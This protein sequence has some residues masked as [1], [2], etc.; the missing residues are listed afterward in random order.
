M[1]DPRVSMRGWTRPTAL[2]FALLCLVGLRAHDGPAMGASAQDVRAGRWET[3]ANGDDILVLAGEGDVLWA[4][5]RAGGL[6]RW[7]AADGRYV[8]YLRPQ[9][10]LGGNTVTD[11]A[12]DA[13][14]RKWLATD[15]GLTMLD[16]K[17]TAD[18][19]DDVWR[20]YTAEATYG[21]LPSDDV[22]TVAVDG[23]L[24]WVGTAQVWNP[25]TGAYEGG[26]LAR[27]DTK[28][29]SATADDTWMPPATFADTITPAPD[30]T[31]DLGLVSDNVT[32]LV[33]TADR[34][35]WVATAPHWLYEKPPV[36]ELEARWGR[37]HGGIS[38][39]DTKG[40][41]DPS[42]DKWTANDCEDFQATITCSVQAMAL[43]ADGMVWAAIGGRGVMYFPAATPVIVDERSRRFDLESGDVDDFVEGIA[44]GPADDP[45]FADTVWLARRK[46][47]LSVLDHNGTL[48]NR[49]DDLW[50]LDR[51]QP[52]G[53]ADGL[54]ADRV[55]AVAVSG[56]R[57]WAGTGAADG[58][59]GGLSP[60][61]LRDLAVE[62][63]LRTTNAPP[64]NFLTALDF[65][66][67]GTKWAGHVWL[68]TGSRAQR[69][70]GAGVVDLDTKGTYDRRDDTWTAYTSAG[71]DDDGAAPWSGLAGDNVQAVAVAGDRVWFGSAESTWSQEARRYL[72]GGAAVFDGT[73]WTAR[74]AGGGGQGLGHGSVSSL[75]VGC[76]GEL[77]IG[78][79]NRW[80]YWGAGIDVLRTGPDVHD[81]TT[82]RWVRHRHPALASNNT[83]AIATDCAQGRVWVAAEH[84]VTQGDPENM[85][86]GGNLV[87]GGV[88]M[89]DI[90]EETWTRYGKRQGFASYAQG[91]I[92]GEATTIAVGPDGTVWAGA[93]GTADTTTSDL[94]TLRPFYPATLNVR[95]F[96]AGAWTQQVFDGAGYVSAVA[97]DP[98]GRAWAATSRGGAARDSNRA[99][100]WRAD[101]FRGGL[102]VRDGDNW[103]RFDVRT[104]G[105]PTND[106]ADLAIAPDGDVWLV[107]EGW[108][109]ARYT[110]REPAPTATPT[111]DA[112]TPTP[113][114]T[115]TATATRTQE[116]TP[117]GPTPSA[118]R[119]TVTRTPG[120][121]E[122]YLPFLARPSRGVVR[123]TLWLPLASGSG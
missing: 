10:P 104:S 101:R 87:G 110:T 13:D 79:G 71:T 53:A 103:N 50:D 54:G 44:F 7:N 116:P 95:A 118:T 66:E 33:V 45:D 29:T 86:S 81:A 84:H 72:D 15:G 107:T 19:A 117:T 85:A 89:Y 114:P 48:R 105:L 80:D 25:E 122:A 8:Q 112:P 1:T 52:F 62:P 78:T 24:V 16:D 55:Q 102:F 82:D 88:A 57:A 121:G 43:D 74:A 99:E 30:G 2:V 4:G 14:G 90:D 37:R 92:D 6:V 64:T 119:P 93:Y 106:I 26:G 46:G 49:S 39:L 100:N 97:V 34:R 68:A 111:S 32:D 40:T 35:L 75:A 18:R 47:G 70:F 63:A 120:G 69:L 38:F 77:W 23:A 31:Q 60:I 56:G 17:G 83:T 67:P 9:D 59:A 12:I 58:V 20:T 115:R 5:T 96:G 91:F 98:E 22:R 113:S 109:A 123:G 51:G 94:V 76:A 27:L 108:G 65:G 36:P 41:V 21:G 61:A 73:D 42:D 11:I 3:I 28:G